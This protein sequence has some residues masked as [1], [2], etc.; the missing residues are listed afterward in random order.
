MN[1]RNVDYNIDFVANA[2]G[3]GEFEGEG[4]R[5]ERKER[6]GKSARL[7]MYCRQDTLIAV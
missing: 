2:E 5:R 7:D 1:R 4:E 6:D 3:E